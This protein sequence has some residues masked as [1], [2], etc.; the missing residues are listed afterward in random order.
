MGY[1]ASKVPASFKTHPTNKKGRLS[2]HRRRVGRRR[3]KRGF[4][5]LTVSTG[6]S[7]RFPKPLGQGSAMPSTKPSLHRRRAESLRAAVAVV[8]VVGGPGPSCTL[9]HGGQTA[10]RAS[11]WWRGCS[12]DWP[13]TCLSTVTGGCPISMPTPTE[14]RM[15]RRRCSVQFGGYVQLASESGG[16]RVRRGLHDRQWGGGGAPQYD[17]Q[18][19]AVHLLRDDWLVWHAVQWSGCRLHGPYS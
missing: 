6:R 17:V 11:M 1:E 10:T 12:I 3:P 7:S 16:L 9:S 14:R 13:W 18:H 15:G 4:R 8:A 2:I 5:A 19:H